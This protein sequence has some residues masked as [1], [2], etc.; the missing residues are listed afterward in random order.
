[1]LDFSTRTRTLEPVVGTGRF[2]AKIVTTT[3]VLLFFAA[4]RIFFV[5]L[6]PVVADPEPR[7]V[8][9]ILTSLDGSSYVNLV[10]GSIFQAPWAAVLGAG[11]ASWFLFRLETPFYFFDSRWLL[12]RRTGL[13]LLIA[14]AGIATPWALRAP[15]S[16]RSAS[17]LSFVLITITNKYTTLLATSVLAGQRRAR[18]WYRRFSRELAQGW[19]AVPPA[20]RARLRLV[21]LLSRADFPDYGSLAPTAAR[22]RRVFDLTEQLRDEAAQAR[23]S[24]RLLRTLLKREQARP[25]TNLLDVRN[26]E[27]TDLINKGRAADTSIRMMLLDRKAVLMGSRGRRV[28]L[29]LRA[30]R[31]SIFT[32]LLNGANVLLVAIMLASGVAVVANPVPWVPQEC[33]RVTGGELFE[34]YL[35]ADSGSI[36][37]VLQQR[38]TAVVNLPANQVTRILDGPCP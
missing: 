17:L 31:L 18:A 13:L 32:V 21:G 23:E 6:D 24:Y 4:A 3:S 36:L 16:W 27:V 37:V 30:L 15:W 7:A 26:S 10:L 14:L 20:A 9:E 25:A 34:G 28:R 22:V 29:R 12:R 19:I 5:T 8:W 1:M 33:F 35:L 11:I 2:A 38:P